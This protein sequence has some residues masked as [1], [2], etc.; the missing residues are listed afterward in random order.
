MKITYLYFI[1]MAAVQ[2]CTGNGAVPPEVPVCVK[3]KIELLKSEPPRN[4]PAYVASYE[5]RGAIVYYLPPA[6]GDQM[7]ELYNEKC[8]LICKPDGGITGRGDGK[9]SDFSDQRANEKILWR[10]DR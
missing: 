3:E 9:C 4:P 10:D 8:E 1:L 6:A 7:S 5:Y 2:N